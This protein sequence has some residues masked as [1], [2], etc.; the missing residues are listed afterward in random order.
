MI[1]ALEQGTILYHGSYTA[2]VQPDIVKCAKNK[3]FGQGFYLTTDK[4]Q[5][6]NFA[7]IAL[8]KAYQNYLLDSPQD[9]GVVSAFKYSPDESLA[10]KTFETADSQWLRCIV[11][12][13]KSGKF[14][15][16]V[17]DYKHYDIIGGKIANDNTNAT[18]MLYMSGG[19]GVVG[20]PQAENT[21]INLLLPER[22]K[23]QYC[24]RTA[25]ALSC[26]TFLW[27]RRVICM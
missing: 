11:A 13:R 26:L 23:D 18:I 6:D 25:K 21:C 12:H 16:T 20:S 24:F 19:Y 8:Q 27:Q 1:K 9:Y 2:V 22:L 4:A 17:Q 7:K 15:Q 10:I 3:D 5:A 14:K